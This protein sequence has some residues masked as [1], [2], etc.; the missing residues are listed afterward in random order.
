MSYK[1]FLINFSLGIA[2]LSSDGFSM[3]HSDSD[4]ES[5]ADLLPE[6]ENEMAPQH[7]G[8][9]PH[10]GHG[11]GMMGGH[12]DT[13]A[14][15][16]AMSQ[17]QV[18]AAFNDALHINNYQ[19]VE[20][21]LRHKWNDIPNVR[22]LVALAQSTWRHGNWP[23]S[24]TIQQ[25][26][27]HYQNGDA[28][29]PVWEEAPPP[30]PLP[31]PGHD[32]GG[33]HH[34]FDP[35]HGFG[36]G[37]GGMHHGFGGG[38]MGGGGYPP[39]SPPVPAEL[40]H[41]DF[42]EVRNAFAAISNDHIPDWIYVLSREG[43]CKDIWSHLS[44]K[45]KEK[46]ELQKLP[47]GLDAVKVFF[48]GSVL[49]EKAITQWMKFLE[50]KALREKIVEYLAKK[51][52]RSFDNW[53]Q[54]LGHHKDSQKFEVLS[55]AFLIICDKKGDN[56]FYNAH[57]DVGINAETSMA[58]GKVAF[59]QAI[60][61]MRRAK[62]EDIHYTA[63]KYHDL[64]ARLEKLLIEERTK[65]EKE[66]LTVTG[67][68]AGK[69]H[70]ELVQALGNINRQI[71][72]YNCAL[73]ALGKEDKIP[74]SF[75]AFRAPQEINPQFV[76]DHFLNTEIYDGSNI[77]LAEMLYNMCELVMREHNESPATVQLVNLFNQFDS[78][79]NN[80]IHGD[81]IKTKDLYNQKGVF[82]KGFDSVR[83]ESADEIKK[84]HTKTA[85]TILAFFESKKYARTEA[86]IRQYL[87]HEMGVYHEDSNN[88]VLNNHQ[89]MSHGNNE[90]NVQNRGQKLI[91]AIKS[92]KKQ[93]P[94][95]ANKEVYEKVIQPH[96]KEQQVGGAQGMAKGLLKNAIDESVK[97]L[98]RIQEEERKR[99]E[100]HATNYGPVVQKF[101][102]YAFDTLRAHVG[103]KEDQISFR[104]H[105]NRFELK[106]ENGSEDDHKTILMTPVTND[107]KDLKQTLFNQTPD[108]NAWHRLDQIVPVGF[109]NR[110]TIL[111]NL[112]GYLM[113][114][115]QLTHGA[116][117]SMG[118]KT[119]L[120]VELAGW[121][122]KVLGDKAVHLGGDI[123]CH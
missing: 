98:M 51:D 99:K 67:G 55:E 89:E 52:S 24:P 46:N 62:H 20:Q 32:M 90:V 16:M 11:G 31:H 33:M 115:Q 110:A 43:L 82:W 81:I 14:D 119:R 71:Y 91:D 117:C 107:E 63:E 114:S 29:P 77:K 75:H 57:P 30:P 105:G 100:A 116:S 61:L 93:H 108:D 94:N 68:M 38:W 41:D 69:N 35:H 92:Y 50:N 5:I 54:L 34:G 106:V 86:E 25:I 22:R 112:Q 2:T 12:H 88:I 18:R 95:A 113:Y 120:M 109:A 118:I 8:F 39:A 97:D 4:S 66:R 64:L 6:E 78:K 123:D 21:I 44:A 49:E 104:R 1:Q 9:A 83:H 96:Q 23:N 47:Q 101:A 10:V 59:H 79:G 15:I 17:E 26:F 70:E 87:V 103:D 28:M 73:Y 72:K 53:A 102:N 19:R 13:P 36:D 40:D 76:R 122:L 45:L 56:R 121:D 3:N 58:Y 85:E 74:A 111:H 65:K 42:D 37:M 27:D 80:N 60:E 84:H 48:G 7:H